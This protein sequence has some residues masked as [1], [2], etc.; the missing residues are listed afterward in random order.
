MALKIRSVRKK[1]KREKAARNKNPEVATPIF[2][3]YEFRKIT[4]TN[5]RPPTTIPV[6]TSL[7]RNL[8]I[9][10]ELERAVINQKLIKRKNP[11]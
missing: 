7:P 9:F 5:Q 3:R 10:K 8:P 1:R 11:E 6:D 4:A 2:K